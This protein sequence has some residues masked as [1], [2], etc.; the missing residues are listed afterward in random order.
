MSTLLRPVVIDS[1][2]TSLRDRHGSSIHPINTVPRLFP[3]TALTGDD[4]VCDETT[5]V[6][7]TKAKASGDNVAQNLLPVG[8]PLPSNAHLPDSATKITIPRHLDATAI[9][10]GISTPTASSPVTPSFSRK[11]SSAEL[12]PENVYS[13][14]KIERLKWRLAAGFFTYFL[15]GWGDGVTATV[16]PYFMADFHLSSM[17]LSLIFLGGACGFAFGSFTVERVLNFLG[18][19]N[20]K[21][22]PGWLFPASPFLLRYTG[23]KVP[24]ENIAHSASQARFLVLMIGCLLHSS[25]FVLMASRS[26]F[27]VMFVAYASA[28]FGRALW[29]APL[30]AYYAKGPRHA[31]VISFGLWSLGGVSSPLTAQAAIAK[32]V[33]WP[34]FYYGSLVISGLNFAFLLLTYRPTASELLEERRAARKAKR[35]SSDDYFFGGSFSATEDG[36][37]LSATGIST[38]TQ[39]KHTLR[40][41]LSLPIFWAL[42]ATGMLYSGGETS[43]VG[44]MVTFLLRARNADP[45]SAGFVTS[46]FWGGITIARFLLGYLSTRSAPASHL[47]S[48]KILHTGESR[49]VVLKVAALSSNPLSVLAF[50]MHLLIWLTKSVFGNALCASII[51]LL[52]GPIFPCLLSMATDILPNEVHL[53]GMALI[54]TASSAGTALFPFVLGT[55]LKIDG[56]RAMSYMTVPLVVVLGSLWAVLPSRIPTNHIRQGI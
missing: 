56:A 26:G 22:P 28:A 4:V 10:G 3:T 19:F 47:H 49:S 6:D 18:Q 14:Q 9:I 51:G 20:Y 37:S 50:V 32:G 53:V 52:Y 16:L 46:G 42:A 48:T 13:S 1:C 17:I 15:C 5:A 29:L 11:V 21:Y 24:K 41:T 31:M 36:H 38:T 30:N 54:S 12:L 40:R 25:F 39:K 55:I 7:R 34:N 35:K 2:Q 33:P 44:F 43:S 23:R 8:L 45:S 27:P